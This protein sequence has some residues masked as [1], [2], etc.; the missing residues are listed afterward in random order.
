[1]EQTILDSLQFQQYFVG[2]LLSKLLL[3]T[4]RGV[5]E[6]FQTLVLQNWKDTKIL[7]SV[8]SIDFCNNR[9]HLRH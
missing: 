3:L 5:S 9:V 7:R 8:A 6:S 4:K 1:M 2:R